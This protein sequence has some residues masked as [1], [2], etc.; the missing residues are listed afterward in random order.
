MATTAPSTQIDPKLL[1]LLR[2]P[3]AVHYTDRGADPGK[4]QLVGESY[5]L[6][7]PD[8]GYKYPIIDGIPKM[9]VEEG[10]KWKDTPLED[11]PVPPPNEPIYAAA[12]DA[13]TPEMQALANELSIHAEDTRADAVQKLRTAA[14]NI[15]T[16]ARDADPDGKINTRAND[17][18]AGLEE[19]ASFVQVGKVSTA[20]QSSSERPWMIWV[21]LFVIGL[22]FG[23]M[24][25]GGKRK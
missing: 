2:C 9:L 14:Q 25:R 16:Q 22:L 8:S 1:D 24:L 15:R 7:S 18:A 23:L 12:E 4:L 11:L 17:I 20:P 3:V 6:Y 21:F 19:A 10:A 13:L 5:W